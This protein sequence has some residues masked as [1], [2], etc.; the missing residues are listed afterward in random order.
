MADSYVPER[1]NTVIIGAGQAGLSAGYHLRQRG[2]PF[3]ILDANARVGD[4]WRRRWDSLRLFTPAR[5]ASLDG[6]PY[7]ALPGY[8]PTKD[9][10]AD[11]LENY[12][13]TFAL[14]VRSNTRVERISKSGDE[15]L[16]VAGPQRYLAKNVIVA[17]SNYQR[18]RIP[19]FASELRKDVVQLH[20]ID[21]RNPSQLQSGD[22]AVVGA[23]NSGAEIALELAQ[24]HRVFVAGRDTGEVPFRINGFVARL[25]LYRFVLR[26]LFH[27]ILSTATPIGRK[28]RPKVLHVAAPL[29]RVKRRDLAAARVKRVPSVT[30]VKDGL[31]LLADGTVLD[32]HNVIWCSGFDSDFSWIDLP[33]FDSHGD[34]RHVN[35][36]VE[37]EP[38][39]YFVGLHFLRAFSSAMVHGVGRDA[40]RIAGHIAQRRELLSGAA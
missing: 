14:P 23:G 27:R 4:T 20:A 31:P 40:E 2:I 16:V 3:V 22:V 38:G 5:H 25:F 8:F 37:D 28:I 39:L 13:R 33:V 34:P 26:V 1:I 19:Q 18:A 17:M 12:V 21:Y 15:F 10:F 9:E 7:P 29:I 36:V 32:V 35:G 11:Y 30:G 24:T 6:M